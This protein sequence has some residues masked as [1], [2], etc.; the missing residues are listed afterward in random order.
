MAVTWLWLLRPIFFFS[1][2]FPVTFSM[3]ESEALLKLKS[4]F[5]NAKALDSWMPSTA[6]CRGGE[7]EWSGVVCSEGIVTGLYINSM[8][9]S[10]KIDVDALT[11]L[12]GLRTFSVANNSFSGKTPEFSRL[13]GLRAIY[14]DK[15]Q[16]SSEIP[17]GYFDEMGALRKLW[18]SNNKFRG[19]L[20]PS[21]FNLPHLTELHLESNQF[22]GT[23]PSF[24]QPTLVRLN[25]SSNKLE[26]EIPA[27]LLRFN[28]SS[29]SGNAGL[30][31]KNLG[32]ECRNAKASAANK[33]IHPPPPPH[34][35][36]ENV[37]DSKKVIAAGVA[38]S[39]MLV[40]IAIVVIIRI[41][42]KRKAFKVLEKESVQAVEVRVSVPNKSR[43]VDVSR[44]A[45]SSRRGSSHHGKNSGVGELVLVNGQKGVFGLPD[46][47]KAAAEVLGNGGLGSSY[48]AMMADGVTVVVKR[49]KESSAMARDA[50]DTE[51]RRLG[52]LRHSNVLAPLAYH[53]RAD[54]KLLVYEYIPGGSLLYLLHG[55]KVPLLV[56]FHQNFKL[57][58]L[59][60]EMF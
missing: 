51:V 21:L 53:Y 10:G 16:F 5:T 42:R 52:R 20:P 34:P 43:D 23:I 28:A 1:I 6:P 25:L 48:K 60:T 3:S 26:G 38:L 37:D 18:F 39:V 29:F 56:K 9:L 33:N 15:N 27:S 59:T 55:K 35:A 44:K 58:S 14:L 4:S 45:S 19:R 50:F 2:T 11:E 36:A 41:R 54:E 17:P 47:M 12:T 46:L 24:D 8:G 31:G 32:V 22:N 30:C 7:E 40:S 57:F 49:M 13:G